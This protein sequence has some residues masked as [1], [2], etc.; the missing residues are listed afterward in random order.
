MN[1]KVLVP[2]LL[3]SFGFIPAG[4]MS[5]SDVSLSYVEHPSDDRPATLDP[6]EAVAMISSYRV[7]HGLSAVTLDPT[8]MAVATDHAR[9]MAGSGTLA[10]V[11]PGE[12]SFENRIAA[13][14]Y[15]AAVAAENI[16]AGYHNLSEAFSGWRASPHH[17]ENML[18]PGVTAIGIA[19]AYTQKSKF[20]D[21]WS[22]V[23]AGP[24]DRNA[25]R[26]PSGGPVG[27]ASLLAPQ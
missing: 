4:C 27:P 1:P 17:N 20:R 5:S 24:F 7:S 8:L 18:R 19:T 16:G 21:F 10:H 6:K 15:D 2:L 22:L 23:L 14:G 26:G 25:M 11:L 12:V 9:A 3:L 13:H